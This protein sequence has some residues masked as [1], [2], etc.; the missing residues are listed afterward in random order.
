MLVGWYKG[1]KTLYHVWLDSMSHFYVAFNREG[2]LAR[3]LP[4]Y[5]T[6]TVLPFETNSRTKAVGG[7]GGDEGDDLPMPPAKA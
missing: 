5:R 7:D 2:V 4:G 6:V 1:E 3:D